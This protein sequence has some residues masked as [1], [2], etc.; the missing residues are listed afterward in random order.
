MWLRRTVKSE[1]VE[2]GNY[3]G[4]V[5]D[6]AAVRALANMVKEQSVSASG[7]GFW[8]SVNLPGRNIRA[9][10]IDEL[11]DADLPERF[12]GLTM[13]FQDQGKY[14][15]LNID[16]HVS[17]SVIGTDQQ[18]VF[19][20]QEALSRYLMK[21]RRGWYGRVYSLLRSSTGSMCAC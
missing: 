2:K 8:A 11:L 20:K 15:Y 7:L 10:T 6:E 3:Y 12:S 5:L 17:F 9:N 1:F 14:V 21:K 18:W 19:G 13:N 4:C 16:K